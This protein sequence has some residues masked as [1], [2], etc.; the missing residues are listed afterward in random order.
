MMPAD[1]GIAIRTGRPED[2]A[3]VVRLEN[4]CFAD[5]W[6]PASLLGELTADAMR[7]PLMA[8]EAGTVVGYLMSWRVA[9]L[10]HVLN[11]AA[12]PD[13]RRRGVGT[14]LLHEA[15]RRALADGIRIAT[16]EVRRSNTAARA[17]YRK[18]GFTESGIRTGYYGDNGE[19]AIVMDG[20]LT[21]LAD[22]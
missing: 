20:E 11:I 12:D 17:F 21:R 3:D 5:P 2:L 9:D 7:L 16:L 19:D 13:R 22:P 6:S 4:A 14:A 10:L 8:E 18:R 15:A 1:S